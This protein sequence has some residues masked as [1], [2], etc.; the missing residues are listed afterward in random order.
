M[1]PVRGPRAARP[2]RRA[3]E[4]IDAAAAVFAERGY[5][6]ASTQDV[7]DHLGM[8]QASLY[9]YFPSKESALEQVC[10]RSVGDFLERAQ[11]IANGSGGSADKL[12]AIIRSHLAPVEERGAYVRC[13][14]RERRFLPRESARRIGRVARRYEHILQSVIEAGIAA[15]ELRRDLDPRLATLALVGMCNAA[16][17]WYGREPNAP[18]GLIVEVFTGLAISGMAVPRH[19]RP[20]PPS[21]NRATGSGGRAGSRQRRQSRG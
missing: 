9:Y 14:L 11:A 19:G 7:A 13:F 1:P 15:G 10:L 12:A 4:I 20:R 8:R 17:E 21:G 18:L 16:M 5:H 6:G 3:D 2:R